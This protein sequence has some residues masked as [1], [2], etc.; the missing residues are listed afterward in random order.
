MGVG[1]V[2]ATSLTSRLRMTVGSGR[3]TRRIPLVRCSYQ[4]LVC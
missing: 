3:V 1:T 2:G 4:S